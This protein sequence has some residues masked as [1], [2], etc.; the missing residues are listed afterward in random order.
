MLC[1]VLASLQIDFYHPLHN[2]LIVPGPGHYM[3]QLRLAL[4]QTE[5]HLPFGI[6]QGSYQLR[7]W[8]VEKVGRKHASRVFAFS[9]TAIGSMT[10][11][12]VQA[13]FGINSSLLNEV[14]P[15]CLSLATTL[16][17]E[18]FHITFTRSSQG[19]RKVLAFDVP[20]T[21]KKLIP[22]QHQFGG[23]MIVVAHTGGMPKLFQPPG[24]PVYC[25][26][27]KIVYKGLPS[28]RR[29]TV[30]TPNSKM[31][32][33]VTRFG[34]LK[35]HT[36]STSQG[37]Y[38]ANFAYEDG[39]SIFIPS[40]ISDAEAY[41]CLQEIIQQYSGD[42]YRDTPLDDQ[43]RVK[44]NWIESQ[45]L[46][47]ANL[48]SSACWRLFCLAL[49]ANTEMSIKQ[50]SKTTKGYSIIQSSSL[51]L[52]GFS[53]S[54]LCIA[55][56]PGIAP[57]QLTTPWDRITILG[58]GKFDESTP[59]PG[60]L[61]EH[62]ESQPLEC[63]AC[64]DGQSPNQ[65]STNSVSKNPYSIADDDE[66]PPVVAQNITSFIDHT[67]KLQ[68]VSQV[69]LNIS[70]PVVIQEVLATIADSERSEEGNLRID[71]N[72]FD[73]PTDSRIEPAVAH[74]SQ[75]CCARAEP[76]ADDVV[77][78][79]HDAFI[80]GENLPVDSV[81]PTTSDKA[82][83]RL[84]FS[85]EKQSNVEVAQTTVQD[86]YLEKLNKVEVEQDASSKTSKSPMEKNKKLSGVT[87]KAIP[88]M[89]STIH[90]LIRRNERL[91]AISVQTPV[92]IDSDLDELQII[93]GTSLESQ[94][95]T[96][97]LDSQLRRIMDLWPNTFWSNLMQETIDSAKQLNHICPRSLLLSEFYPNVFHNLN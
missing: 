54:T 27:E 76:L 36:F 42:K 21:K 3:N 13:E 74:E 84:E 11:A 85:F 79:N 38:E 78:L 92:P 57:K 62:L 12:P 81:I 16:S 8:L 82:P 96:M 28:V 94:Q 58:S 97:L 86:T 6:K 72:Q 41:N 59:S 83:K 32:N 20:I 52:L 14:H 2:K 10:V 66:V 30:L 77:A 80:E 45:E 4:L 37:T 17:A 51:S 64:E 9:K 91:R 39:P 22:Y 18:N 61:K 53:E 31:P 29:K 49:P 56:P 87:K 69:D 26:S 25:E 67:E 40:T 60:H 95:S 48:L 19:D 55:I 88:T 73:L 68:S 75:V 50:I 90:D 46:A 15:A 44:L 34:F 7:H 33:S 1:E 63:H 89:Q 65:V 35:D 23:E 5:V 24:A 71:Q 93:S 47:L 43:L 70:S